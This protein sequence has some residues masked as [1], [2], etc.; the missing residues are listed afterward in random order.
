MDVSVEVLSKFITEAYNTHTYRNDPWLSRIASVPIETGRIPEYVDVPQLADVSALI[1]GGRSNTRNVGTDFLIGTGTGERTID[2]P[3][4][5]KD[6]YL[7]WRVKD[8][9]TDLL[10][11]PEEDTREAGGVYRKIALQLNNVANELSYYINTTILWEIA[12]NLGSG[13]IIESD[14]S[15]NDQ[16]TY[17]NKGRRIIGDVAYPVNLRAPSLGELRD[18]MRICRDGWLGSVDPDIS[19]VYCIMPELMFYEIIDSNSSTFNN[20]SIT[21]RESTYWAL[22]EMARLFGIRIILRNQVLRCDTTDITKFVHPGGLSGT[23][24]AHPTDREA[25][26]LFTPGALLQYRSAPRMFASTN[27]PEHLGN[28]YRWQTDYAAGPTT[29]SSITNAHKGV[30]VLTS[31]DI[32]V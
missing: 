21:G 17:A 30:V 19:D 11:T 6:S 12:N 15:D 25:C 14:Q 29:T 26:L 27:R 5:F 9:T 22:A 32:S 4:K 23:E 2:T 18:A 31:K 1:T 8:Y 20:T 10:L 24:A 28:L 7:S 16:Y 3:V 13:D